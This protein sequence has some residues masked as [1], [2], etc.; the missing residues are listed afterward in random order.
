MKIHP[1]KQ[2]QPVQTTSEP[3]ARAH[4]KSRRTIKNH[5]QQRLLSSARPTRGLCS[6]V[7]K[8]IECKLQQHFRSQRNLHIISFVHPLT[9]CLNMCITYV[10][11]CVSEY[12]QITSKLSKWLIENAELLSYR[13]CTPNCSF[14]QQTK[15][16]YRQSHLSPSLAASVSSLSDFYSHC[17]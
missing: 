4:C 13:Y 2:A 11:V 3:R 7:Y 16:I 12:M 8:S 5:Q 15:N 17:V 10:Y 9:C 1:H 6:L 14:C